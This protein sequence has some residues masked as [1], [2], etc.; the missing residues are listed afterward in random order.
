MSNYIFIGSWFRKKPCFWSIHP[1][2][3]KFSDRSLSV[4]VLLCMCL[5]V[6]G[7]QSGP[8]LAGVCVGSVWR[9][10]HSDGLS[11]HGQCGVLSVFSAGEPTRDRSTGPPHRKHGGGECGGDEELDSSLH[12]ETRFKAGDAH[13]CEDVAGW[14]WSGS[15]CRLWGRLCSVM[16][17]FPSPSVQ[18][19]EG[20]SWASHVS[21]HWCMQAERH[22]RV[23]REDTPIL[24][25]WQ[26]A[27]P[28]DA[29]LR[30]DDQSWGLPATYPCRRKDPRDCG[31]GQQ[32]QSVWLEETE[33]IG[34]SATSYWHGEY[35]GF[36]RPSGP[37]T[38][39]SGRRVQGPA[40][41]CVVYI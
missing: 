33:A 26:P 35:C 9:P 25:P 21:R 28:S 14:F 31:M 15:V 38:E 27:K 8:G 13:V 29:R 2:S 6:C 3:A 1:K 41:Q 23:F 39:T 24:D 36:L 22:L 20:T 11:P 17:C 16:G 4:F 18:L 32:H 40:D 7:C 30:S 12:S 34:C 10:Q 5:C 37:P 19:S